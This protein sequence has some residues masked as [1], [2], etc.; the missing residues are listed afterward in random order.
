MRPLLAL[1]YMTGMVTACRY[2]PPFV[3]GTTRCAAHSLACPGLLV[4]E[5]D[6][7]LCVT[8]RDDAASAVS[9]PPEDA[10]PPDV[11]TPDLPGA[12]GAAITIPQDGGVIEAA[13]TPDAAHD[14]GDA[15]VD[16]PIAD[17]PGADRAGDACPAP[18]PCACTPCHGAVGP[19]CLDRGV[20][21]DGGSFE[22]GVCGRQAGERCPIPTGSASCPPGDTCRVV[23]GQVACVRP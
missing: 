12:D 20:P 11:A 8:R 4:C 16:R 18:D 19:T 6:A 22:Y 5:P 14:A 15:P 21:E 13:V 10:G 9:P 3:P 1:L 23:A 2:N 17:A 7:G